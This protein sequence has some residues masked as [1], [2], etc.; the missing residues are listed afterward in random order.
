M[1]TVYALLCFVV[2]Y[3]ILLDFYPY[4]SRLLHWHWGNHMIW[5]PQCQWSNPEGYG[6]INQWIPQEIMIQPQQDKPKQNCVY[7]LWDNLLTFNQVNYTRNCVSVRSTVSKTTV[8]ESVHMSRANLS[9][10]MLA[11]TMTGLAGQ[12]F[13]QR[14][15][16]A[17]I[18]NKEEEAVWKRNKNQESF[19]FFNNNKAKENK[20]TWALTRLSH[21]ALLVGCGTRQPLLGLLSW[22]PIFLFKSL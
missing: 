13:T 11:V 22:Y 7:N 3:H 9:G 20:V 12:D 8:R 4:P 15:F 14:V 2:V 19:I 21:I 10:F 17:P 18:P 1:H 16:W 5:L 6:W